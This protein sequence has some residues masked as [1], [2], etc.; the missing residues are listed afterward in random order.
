ME[1]DLLDDYGFSDWLG[2]ELHGL[3][4]HSTGMVKDP[5][6][7]DETIALLRRF[8]AEESSHNRCTERAASRGPYRPWRTLHP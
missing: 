3:G 1:A 5:F 4:A 7:A 6:T 8:D 2:P